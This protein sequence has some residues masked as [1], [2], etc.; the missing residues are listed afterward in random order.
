M[1]Y[2]FFSYSHSNPKIV[3]LSPFQKRKL[4]MSEVKWILQRQKLIIRNVGTGLHSVQSIVLTKFFSYFWII[5]DV[6]YPVLNLK[7]SF[8]HY[9]VCKMKCLQKNHLFHLIM[10]AVVKA[11]SRY[12]LVR[13]SLFMVAKWPISGHLKYKKNGWIR[14]L[15]L[16]KLYFS[17]LMCNP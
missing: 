13:L 8:N 17:Y 15:K 2:F 10:N 11:C 7:F 16:E 5:Q 9:L 1:I 3:L 14:T 4:K 12:A 6:I